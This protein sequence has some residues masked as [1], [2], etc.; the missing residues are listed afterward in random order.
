MFLCKQTWYVEVM[1]PYNHK[2]KHPNIAA[3]SVIEN[4]LEV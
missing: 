4:I 2:R 3:I 1:F